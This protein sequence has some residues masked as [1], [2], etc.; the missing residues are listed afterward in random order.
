MYLKQAIIKNFRIFN[1]TYIFNIKDFTTILG[2]NDIGKENFYNMS[3]KVV[4]S[5]NL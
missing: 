3:V 5:A 2:K 1:G 4:N